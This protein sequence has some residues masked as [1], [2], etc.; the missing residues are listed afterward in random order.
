MDDLQ[1]I[2]VAE[3][4]PV[5]PQKKF[6]LTT[7][8]EDLSDTISEASALSAEGYSGDLV[9]TKDD[10]IEHLRDGKSSF[11]ALHTTDVE[12]REV[13]TLDELV[14]RGLY[15]LDSG[16]VLDVNSGEKIPLQ[17]AIEQGIVD[18]DSVRLCDPLTGK[19]ITLTEAFER[20]IMDPDNGNIIDSYS[21][22]TISF[23]ESVKRA[24]KTSTTHTVPVIDAR[25]LPKKVQTVPLGEALQS[26]MYNQERNVFVDPIT[27]Q[28]LTLDEAIKKHLIDPEEQA[29]IDPVSGKSISIK[30]AIERNIIDSKTGLVKGKSGRAITFEQAM[31]RG[32]LT[33]D[34]TKR[35][36]TV[37]TASSATVQ[38]S[39]MDAITNG[40]YD[41]VTKMFVDPSSGRK[42]TLEEAIS[43]GLINTETTM[44]K[45]P[46]TGQKVAFDVLA[47]M[48][49]IDL[50]R[51]IIKDSRG[52]DISI[53]DA[54]RD[55]ILFEAVPL[56]GPFS[57]VQ[58]L[59]EG[60][61]NPD[62]GEFFDPTSRESISLG[63]AISRE[64]LDHASIVVSDPGSSEVLGLKDAIRAGL[65]NSKTSFVKGPSGPLPLS[66][67]LDR[68]IVVAR[69]MMLT[70]AV[71]IG[72]FNETTGKFL[73]PTCRKFFSLEE[74]VKNGLLDDESTI[75]DPVTRRPMV[76]AKA[77]ACGVLDSRN[78]NIINVHTGEVLTL[79]ESITAAKL[80][81]SQSQKGM[82]MEELISKN[83]FNAAT[84]TVINPVTKEE[85]TLEQA[86]EMGLLDLNSSVPH[87][88][89]GEKITLADAINSDLLEASIQRI[90]VTRMDSQIIKEQ[91]RGGVI[92][93]SLQQALEKGFFNPEDGMFTDKNTGSKI[94]LSEAIR[95]GYLDGNQPAVTVDG[96]PVSLSAAV[97][98]GLIDPVKGTIISRDSSVQLYSKEVSTTT[99]VIRKSEAFSL[100]EAL[101]MGLINAENGNITDPKTG[102]SKNVIEAIK[103]NLIDGS[104]PV[105]LGDQV[106]TLH[107]A[108][109]GGLID[110]LTGN[111]SDPRTK[112]VVNIAD[113]ID[114]G[115]FSRCEEVFEA[116]GLSIQTA[117][118]SGLFDEDAGKL[119]HPRIGERMS[120][121]EAAD[122]GFIDKHSIKFKHPRTGKLLTF[123]EALSVG[124]LDPDTG[125]VISSDGDSLTLKEAIEDGVAVIAT[126][127]KGLSLHDAVQQGIYNKNTGKLVHPTTGQELT[128]EQAIRDGLIDPEKSRIMDPSN[129]NE[130]TILEAI[131][132]KL[133]DPISGKI[134]EPSGKSI[135]LEEAIGNK[136]L[137]DQK[138]PRLSV[139]EAVDLGYFDEQNGIF[140]DP[141][142]G[143]E[144]SL[145][146]ALDAGMLDTEKT[147]LIDARTGETI[148]LL[149]AMKTGLA[150][151]ITGDIIDQQGGARCSFVNAVNMGLVLD[152][153]VPLAYSFS[154]AEQA[155]LFDPTSQLLTNPITGAKMNIVE[156]LRSGLLDPE[157]CLIFLPD[158]GETISLAVALERN[159][160]S[161]DFNVVYDPKTG[162]FEELKS[163]KPDQALHTGVTVI[164]DNESKRHS[165]V[166]R[167]VCFSN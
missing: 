144:M 41:P 83:L 120:I 151:P 18:K 65:V 84:G 104:I 138:P 160:L 165:Y 78:G 103:S 17:D 62:T 79:K 111:Y 80:M 64:L 16:M 39:I 86:L 90:S 101:D 54:S 112:E 82:S 99:K 19:R 55:N 14:K 69:P 48:G 36:N 128:L 58:I 30:E 141:E 145:M 117:I 96:K 92:G 75:I 56:T 50:A 57:L 133:L 126:S 63:E 67:A 46:S 163:I 81:K 142:T 31:E 129:G 26:S 15:D 118:E 25:T 162:L 123:D 108:I 87:P 147:L 124:I 143:K 3:P 47:E 49:L 158:T 40:M 122:I 24:L 105:K 51:G 134:K 43:C 66:E 33:Y 119:I 52:R 91:G 130:I 4:K 139:A 76:L 34:A 153:H 152:A 132:N 93:W 59:E 85:L 32:I 60:L 113:A 166:G 27:G 156:S 121:K 150:D 73:D 72:L 44:V 131:K 149:Q 97:E 95:C 1:I 13:L 12:P 68:G 161:D 109:D 136:M 94:T 100:K 7:T 42:M 28:E 9:F 61:Y 159:L 114:E 167:L 70:S 35:Q 22:K 164:A 38:C 11:S 127:D 107:Q 137:V 77:T 89:T 5:V 106:L 20:G 37:A 154:Q 110:P 148:T 6:S 8:V 155:G 2:E 74:A 71:E 157:K 88:R 98:K 115:L 45:D 140:T 135:S 125:D 102:K 146:D 53:E 10:N 21:S 29:V 23:A 116:Q